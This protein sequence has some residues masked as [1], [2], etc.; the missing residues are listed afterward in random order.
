MDGENTANVR[1]Q[2]SVIKLRVP[3]LNTNMYNK[4][5]DII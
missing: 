5:K 1:V 4:I 2:H 3:L